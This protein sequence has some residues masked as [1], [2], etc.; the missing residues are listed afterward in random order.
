[1]LLIRAAAD[2]FSRQGFHGT[3]LSRICKAAEI[4]MGALTFHFSSK[5][6]LADAVV[7]TG[8]SPVRA[9]VEHVAQRQAPPLERA[10]GLA[11]ELTRLLEADPLVRC[12]VR[13]SRERTGGSAWP[14][15]WRPLVSSLASQAH[16]SGQ[17]DVGALPDDV[18]L[19]IELLVRGSEV[20]LQGADTSAAAGH[21]GS[22]ARLQRSWRLVLNGIAPAAH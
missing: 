11:M 4:S 6:E 22:V 10:V 19:L 2:E 9:L 13:L 1:M 12:A 20:S 15:L 8:L 5:A 16:E 18:T 3:S 17:L 7:E 14:A 21:D